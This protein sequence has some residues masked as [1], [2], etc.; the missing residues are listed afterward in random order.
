MP[1]RSKHLNARSHLEYGAASDTMGRANSTHRGHSRR[2][3]I[4][5]LLL[6]SDQPKSVIP[7][8]YCWGMSLVEEAPFEGS[9]GADC[10]PDPFGVLGA[11]IAGVRDHVDGLRRMGL[12]GSGLGEAVEALVRLRSRVESVEL[13]ALEGYRQ[14]MD[15]SVDG[16]RSVQTWLGD[17]CRLPRASVGAGWGW[18][19]SWMPCR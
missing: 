4:V 15:W 10:G 8:R 3:L 19:G 14:S 1:H 11:A 5:R 18:A 13:T 16:Y 17:R 9:G 6:D 2:T 7:H 12:G